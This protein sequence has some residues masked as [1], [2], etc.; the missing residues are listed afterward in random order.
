M[1]LPGTFGPKL[2]CDWDE[3][4]GKLKG[5]LVCF[6][7]LSFKFV[8][9][10]GHVIAKEKARFDIRAWTIDTKKIAVVPT[11]RTDCSSTDG[12]RAFDGYCV[13]DG[14]DGTP[15]RL[16]DLFSDPLIML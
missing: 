12:C 13:E 8:R 15:S 6:I 4:A 7:N 11:L 14:L 1:Y 2:L 16:A 5:F 3:V 10:A 9:L